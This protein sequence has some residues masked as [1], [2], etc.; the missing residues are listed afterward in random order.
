MVIKYLQIEYIEM[1][2]LNII[3]IIVI[4]LV[5]YLMTINNN[6]LKEVE[7]YITPKELHRQKMKRI[8]GAKYTP[9]TRDDI[10]SW[11]GVDGETPSMITNDD[12]IQ[13]EP[14]K[15]N[16]LHIQWHNDYRDVITA[17]Q[18]LSPAK[19]QLFNHSNIPI[20]YSQPEATEVY[21]IVQDF[22]E[23]INENICNEVPNYRNKNSGWDEAIPDPNEKSGWEQ[24]QESLGLAPSLYD[25]PAGKRNVRLIA[26]QEVEKR[27]TEDEVQHIINFV[28]SK[29]GVEDQM[30]LRASFVQDLRPLRD[31][32]NFNVAN[33]IQIDVSIEE[34]SVIGFLSNEGPDDNLNFEADKDQYYDYKLME[35]NNMTDPR[36]VL[37]KLEEKYNQRNSEMNQMTAL[38]DEEGQAFHSTLPH[39]YDY[40]NIQATQT[41]FDDYNKKRKFS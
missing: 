25:K 28:I 7:N 8:Y 38:L 20:K 22:I 29:Y 34:L 32:N 27:E 3:L 2:T 12:S 11:H 14:V 40:S 41:I 9:T 6:S 17:L 35:Y 31:E 19:K 39:S 23:A 18:N 33:D 21:D 37:S 15:P 16:F 36:Y 4:V 30:V 10:V 5:L 24:I 26:I 1:N 13:Y